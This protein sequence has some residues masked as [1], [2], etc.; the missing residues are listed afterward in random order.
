MKD[1]L[2]HFDEDKMKLNGRIE[3]LINEKNKEVSVLKR[4]LERVSKSKF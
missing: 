4:D 3:S 2:E 1:E